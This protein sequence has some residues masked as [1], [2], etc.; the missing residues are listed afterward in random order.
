[1][2]ENTFVLHLYLIDTQNDAAMIPGPVYVTCLFLKAFGALSLSLVFISGWSLLG[3]F[4]PSLYRRCY[5]LSSQQFSCIIYLITFL[6]PLLQFFLA[7]LLSHLL[8]T[9]SLSL[10]FFNFGFQFLS[11]HILFPTFGKTP[12]FHLPNTY[13]IFFFW[14][15]FFHYFFWTVFDVYW[16]CIYILWKMS[17]IYTYTINIY[18][19]SIKAYTLL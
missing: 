3:I 15:S 8:A 17:I 18:I 4:F 5:V 19:V 11:P 1:M 7:F 9:W 2:S 6:P 12:Q 14:I 16:T 10:V 13:W